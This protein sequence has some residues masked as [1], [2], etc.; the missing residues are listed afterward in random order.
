LPQQSLVLT[1]AF[2]HRQSTWC[3]FRATEQIVHEQLESETQNVRMDEKTQ[4][5]KN[6]HKQL[7]HLDHLVAVVWD[8]LCIVHLEVFVPQHFPRISHH[9]LISISGQYEL[10]VTVLVKQT[11]TTHTYE[12][13]YLRLGLWGKVV[14]IVPL[15]I[16]VLVVNHFA[17]WSALHV[18][19]TRLNGAKHTMTKHTTMTNANLGNR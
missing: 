16:V 1:F 6:K 11:K 7:I 10:S 8:T 19:P 3:K 4:K 17:M 13:K 15:A 12:T 2:Y 14:E 9:Q 5:T 18:I